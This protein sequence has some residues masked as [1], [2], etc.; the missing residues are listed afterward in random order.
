MDL[1]VG[2][3]LRGAEGIQG[4]TLR[5]PSGQVATFARASAGAGVDANGAAYDAAPH[6]PAV[7][8]T[9]GRSGIP[10]RPADAPRA[11]ETLTIAHP[12]PIV[13]HTGYIRFVDRGAAAADGRLIHWGD[14]ADADPRLVVLSTSNRFA[15]TYDPSTPTSSQMEVGSTPSAGDLVQIWWHLFSDGS[16]LIRQAVNDGVVVSA[17]ASPSNATPPPQAASGQFIYVGGRSASSVGGIELQVVR[18]HPDP[19]VSFGI[20]QGGSGLVVPPS[21][22]TQL[23]VDLLS[24]DPAVVGFVEVDGWLEATE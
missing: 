4:R 6:R 18:L 1:V 22:E 17:T 21:L 7:S 11:V 19:E 24:Q 15:V 14:A 3:L 10:I 5:L 23:V 16:V 20:M 13:P 2:D 12:G 9:S 8:I